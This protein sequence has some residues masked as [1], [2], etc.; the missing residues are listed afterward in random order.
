MKRGWKY[1]RVTAE[2][3]Q[4][5]SEQAPEEGL[6]DTIEGLC[7]REHRKEVVGFPSTHTLN[8]ADLQCRPRRS[9]C[10]RCCGPCA[11]EAG[12]GCDVR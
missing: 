4:R 7:D 6:E 1:V 12:A 11:A 3:P 8:S 5:S 2:W 10:Q 9:P